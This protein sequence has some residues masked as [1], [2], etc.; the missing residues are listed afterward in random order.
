M[1][2]RSEQRP[3]TLRARRLGI[4]ISSDQYACAEYPETSRATPENSRAC[5]RITGAVLLDGLPRRGAALRARLRAGY[6]ANLRSKLVAVLERCRAW[7]V[8]LVVLPE[9]SVP[10]QL[11]QDV[12]MA[13]GEM[14]VVA[15]SHTI[16]REARRSSIYQ[17]LGAAPPPPSPPS[18]RCFIEGGRWRCSPS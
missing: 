10:W 6:L 18:A 15:G 4:D 2:S 1:A 9:Y 11:L 16:D 17:Q 12:V 7:D 14:V 5:Q 3:T 13:G 8:K